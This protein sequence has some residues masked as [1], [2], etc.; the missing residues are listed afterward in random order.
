MCPRVFENEVFCQ[1]ILKFFFHK[2][3]LEIPKYKV[4][5]SEYLKYK[6]K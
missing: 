2:K 5:N 4:L 1:G 3:V 6:V